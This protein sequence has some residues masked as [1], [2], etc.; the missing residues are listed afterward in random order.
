M[1][2][3]NGFRAAGVRAGIKASGNPDLGLIVADA[4]L[5]WAMTGTTNRLRA[6]CVERNQ[7]LA[8]AHAPLRV[9]ATNAGN[10]NAGNGAGGVAAN[11]NFAALCARALGLPVE[12]VITASTGVIGQPLPVDRIERALPEALASLG[13]GLDAFSDAIL[14]TDLVPKHAEV[15]LPGGARIVGVAKGSGMIHP[16]MAT[17]FGFLLTDARIASERLHEMWSAIVERTFNQ[18]SVDG[19]TS[20]NDMAIVL[21]SGHHDADEAALEAGLSEVATSLARAIARDGEG[22]TALI[23]A[24]VRGAHDVVQA[25]RASRAIVSS[26]LVKAAVHGRDPNWGRILSAVGQSQVDADLEHA[27]VTLQGTTVYHQRPL[28]FDAAALSQAMRSPD[29]AI[30]VDLGVGTAEGVAWGCDLSANYV[31]INALYTT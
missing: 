26:S 27:T 2:L 6:P 19:D 1:R 28:P 3:P 7:G 29:V 12:A 21:A 17:M 11:D 23:T 15:T 5:V 10:A 13:E 4:P 16:N 25:R 14:T 30:D 22:A 24:R 18:I 8:A 20:T 9:L 31:M